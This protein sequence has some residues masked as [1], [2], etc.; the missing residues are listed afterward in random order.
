MIHLNIEDYQT[1]R[2]MAFM[3]LQVL[4]VAESVAYGKTRDASNVGAS[5][6]VAGNLSWL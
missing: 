3:V 4:K 2:K 1:R 6:E 5:R